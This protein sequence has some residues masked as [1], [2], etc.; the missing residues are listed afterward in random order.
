MNRIALMMATA[1]VAIIPVA[2]RAQITMPSQNSATDFSVGPQY[3]TTRFYVAPEDFNRVVASFT[4]EV[5]DLAA[6][7]VNATAAC[8]DTLVPAYPEGDRQSA[9]VRIPGGY[10]AEIHAPVKP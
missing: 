6:T 1:L 5:S 3:D 4:A 2:A 7:R 10:I 9:I 8:V